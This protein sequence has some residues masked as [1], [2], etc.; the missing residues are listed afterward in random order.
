MLAGWRNWMELP[1]C[2]DAVSDESDV[3]SAHQTH[4]VLHRRNL[5]V[6][7]TEAAE[8]GK[9]GSFEYNPL[10]AGIEILFRTAVE[11]IVHH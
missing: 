1:W 9:A 8:I 2:K 3:L 11:N 4:S 10:V 6:A 7:G 5:I